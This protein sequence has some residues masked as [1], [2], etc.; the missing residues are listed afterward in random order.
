MKASAGILRIFSMILA[1]TC[2]WSGFEKF[3]KQFV[4]IFMI[5]IDEILKIPNFKSKWKAWETTFL[6]KNNIVMLCK[7]SVMFIEIKMQKLPEKNNKSTQN[8]QQPKQM[9]KS[10]F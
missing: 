3:I 6:L 2:W 4:Y 10:F 9:Q 5:L 8:Y 1:N 7:P